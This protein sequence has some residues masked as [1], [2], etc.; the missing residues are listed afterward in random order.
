MTT[1][2]GK[3]YS[4]GLPCV[5][6]HQ[7]TLPLNINGI[8]NLI[9]LRE[10]PYKLFLEIIVEKKIQYVSQCQSPYN[11][12]RFILTWPGQKGQHYFTKL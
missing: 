1:C 10:A 9:N 12:W 3:S 5:Q 11:V 8:G 6:C 4:F 7:N 2:L